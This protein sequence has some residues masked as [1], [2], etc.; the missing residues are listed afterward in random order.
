MIINCN[1][2][3][4]TEKLQPVTTYYPGTQTNKLKGISGDA[5]K[6]MWVKSLTYCT[7]HCPS[8]KNVVLL[9]GLK[10]VMNFI[11]PH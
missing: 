7:S 11:S 1:S 2:D 10:S 5:K 8:F 9:I 4:D 3:K 6:K